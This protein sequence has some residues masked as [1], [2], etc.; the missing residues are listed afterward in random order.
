VEIVLE[1][2]LEIYALHEKVET[3][4]DCSNLL[5]GFQIIVTGGRSRESAKKHDT[6]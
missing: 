3:H 1:I 2:V 6:G 5:I 4:V